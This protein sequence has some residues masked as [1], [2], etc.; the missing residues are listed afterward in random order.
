MSEKRG[1]TGKLKYDFNTSAVCE[2]QL[3]EGG[4]WFR[5]TAKDFRSFDGP[6][7]LTLPNTQPNL[8]MSDLDS[9]KFKTYPYQGP[10]YMYD[11]NLEVPF[12]NS[13]QTVTSPDK[14]K[15]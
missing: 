9:I 3:K 6:R 2:V 13:R 14:A 4:E 7:Q 1:N 5:T 15:K 10:V 11:T 8:G 12:T